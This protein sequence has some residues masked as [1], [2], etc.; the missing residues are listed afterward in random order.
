MNTITITITITIIIMNFIPS[1][2]R[3]QNCAKEPRTSE[4]EKDELKS[5]NL[6]FLFLLKLKT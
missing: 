1:G 5:V 4:K 2:N 6:L 3:R